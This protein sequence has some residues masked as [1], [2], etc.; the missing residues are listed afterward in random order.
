MNQEDHEKTMEILVCLKAHRDDL[1]AIC[2]R[3]RGD[4]YLNRAY[5]GVRGA[6][7]DL[8]CYA[9]T[10]EKYHTDK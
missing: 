2:S 1:R 7:N 3:L 8:E 9:A 6:V 4:G 5:N 10:L